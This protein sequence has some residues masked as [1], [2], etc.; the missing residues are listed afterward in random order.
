[1]LARVGGE[2]NLTK[3]VA[4]VGSGMQ[5]GIIVRQT[6]VDVRATSAERGPSTSDN[7]QEIWPALYGYVSK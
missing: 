7:E 6:N 3:S 2:P 4:G 1:M 5:R